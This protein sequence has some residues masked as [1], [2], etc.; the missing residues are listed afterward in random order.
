MKLEKLFLLGAIALGL[1]A[2]SNED[3]P[4]V[5]RRKTPQCH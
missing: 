4:V 2:C 3:T 1:A 5:N